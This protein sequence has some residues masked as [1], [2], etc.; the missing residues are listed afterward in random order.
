MVSDETNWIDPRRSSDKVV[1]FT[2]KPGSA[3]DTLVLRSHWLRATLGPGVE[4]GLGRRYRRA[5]L[6]RRRKR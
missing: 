4:V 1:L 2:E 5:V 6:Q 3:V